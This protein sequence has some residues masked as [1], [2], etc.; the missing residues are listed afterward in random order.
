ISP[1]FCCPYGGSCITIIEPPPAD[2]GLVCGNQICCP[3][4][5]PNGTI[6]MVGA[7]ICVNQTQGILSCKN[8]V[9]TGS[10]AAVRPNREN[11]S[12]MTLITATLLLLQL[13][14]L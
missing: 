7:T 4:F 14:Q 5:N 8:G 3:H 10:S 13:F 1:Q 12:I 6:N 9:L 11:I 2:V